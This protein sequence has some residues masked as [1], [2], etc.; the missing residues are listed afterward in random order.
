MKKLI[1][2]RNYQHS[3]FG[4]VTVDEIIKTGETKMPEIVRFTTRSGS[5][6]KQEQGING[7]RFGIGHTKTPWT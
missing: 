2:G 4:G 7:F 3:H 1:I 6:I 5:G